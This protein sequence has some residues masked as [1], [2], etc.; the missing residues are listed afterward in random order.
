VVEMVMIL[1]LA[2]K[3]MMSFP[4]G[5]AMILSRVAKEMMLLKEV[6]VRTY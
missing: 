2:A 6:M 5:Q 3:E 1:L 4:A